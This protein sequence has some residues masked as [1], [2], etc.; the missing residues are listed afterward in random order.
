M[1]GNGFAKQWQRICAMPAERSRTFSYFLL[2]AQQDM[3]VSYPMALPDE[4]G[5]LL[6]PPGHDLKPMIAGRH[7]IKRGAQSLPCLWLCH[8]LA[9]RCLKNKKKCRKDLV[10]EVWT[11]GGVARLQEDSSPSSESAS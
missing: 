7:H 4:P 10:I 1:Q 8:T 5:L 9:Q 2:P 11:S 3:K 6:W